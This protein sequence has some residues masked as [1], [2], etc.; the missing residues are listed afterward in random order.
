M[1]LE[2]ISIIAWI[3]EHKIKTEAGYPLDLKSH[4]FLFKPYSDFSPKQV[5]LKAAQIGYSVLASLKALWAA[6]KKGIDIIY[7][8]PTREDVQVFVGGKVNRIIAQNP[9]LQEY[10]QDKDTVEQ[11]AVGDNMIYYRG[12][13]TKRSAISV[14]ADLLIHDEEDFSDQIIIADYESRLQHSKYAWHWHF[15]HPST[16][17]T[18]ISKYWVK[19]DQKHWFIKCIHC[20]EYQYLSFPESICEE[21]QIY[22]CKKCKKEITDTDRQNGEWVKRYKNKEF[23]GYWI[24]LLI[25][26]WVSAERIFKYHKEKD[27]EYFY[28]RVL[29]LPFVGSGNKVHEDD[30]LGNLTN[31]INAQKGR[32]VI[33]V[34]TGINLD[35]VIGNE[36]G[37]FY[38]GSTK[39]Y[40]DIEKLMKQ[41]NAYA[42]FD[43][44]GDIIGVRE[45]RDKYPGRV[46]LC[47]YRQDRRT[48]ELVQW[49]EDKEM[50]NVIVDRNRMIQLVIDEFKDRRIPLQGNKADWWDFWLHWNNIYRVREEDNLGVMK[51]KWMR[52]G[53][54]H[55]VHSVIYWRVGM[56]KFAG[57]R[58]RVYE[59]GGVGFGRHTAEIGPD[60]NIQMKINHNWEIK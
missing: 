49:G 29:G 27:E 6:K 1:K 44:G 23:S 48:M 26:P 51:N 7:T 15:G 19:S 8:M 60:G 42:V 46:F 56:S 5:T 18:G 45:L 13:M 55:F 58:G 17:G 11:K 28:N 47:H 9:I 35:Y 36:Q 37:L 50:G 4:R 54:D 59:T 24:P 14:T 41:Y 3:Q 20:N 16:E 52:S 12:T 57:G 25:A 32:I 22:Q 40:S 34:D 31:E 39:K 53:H 43:Q 30:I 10:T 33:G 2:D 21:K 38:F